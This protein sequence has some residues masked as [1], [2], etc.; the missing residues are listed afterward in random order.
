MKDKVSVQVSVWRPKIC[1]NNEK[2]TVY[3]AVVTIGLD[4]K[5]V[6]TRAIS[7]LIVRKGLIL[8][9]YY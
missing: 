4:G 9:F 5:K 7:S 1:C 2:R 3:V 8:V 6:G